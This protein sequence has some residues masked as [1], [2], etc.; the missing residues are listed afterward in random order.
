MPEAIKDWFCAC[1]T[2]YNDLEGR[3]MI[4]QEIS[5]KESRKA[6][7]LNGSAIHQTSD[8]E[9][10][11]KQQVPALYEQCVAQRHQEAKLNNA[12]SRKEDH[13]SNNESMGES[14]MH[15]SQQQVTSRAQL[16]A[17]AKLTGSN[18]T[19]TTRSDNV[20]VSE[21]HESDQETTWN[22]SQNEAKYEDDDDNDGDYV[23]N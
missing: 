5:W 19:Q 15:E 23:D 7:K 14:A 16:Q 13:S 11:D 10:G 2:I 1:C 12:K 8:D 9:E 22:S 21:S 20:D 17:A 4:A 6:K 3:D 18:T